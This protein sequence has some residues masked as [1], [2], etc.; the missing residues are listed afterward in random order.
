M[1]SGHIDL[2]KDPTLDLSNETLHQLITLALKCTCMPTAARP[3]MRNVVV[4]LETLR[5]RLLGPR[6]NRHASHIDRSLRSPT[7]RTLAAEIDELMTRTE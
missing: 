5:T 6:L 2:L 3:Q 4:E 1:E 7:N